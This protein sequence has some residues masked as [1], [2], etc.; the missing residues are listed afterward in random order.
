[1][2]CLIAIAR[3][4]RT[5][6][7]VFMTMSGTADVRGILVEISSLPRNFLIDSKN[8]DKSIIVWTN[9]LYHLMH[10]NITKI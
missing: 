6:A 10:F 5:S 1:L 9:I 2:T 3:V 8:F 4:E 7:N